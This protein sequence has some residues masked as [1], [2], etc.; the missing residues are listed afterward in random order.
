MRAKFGVKSFSDQR[1]YISNRVLDSFVAAAGEINE[2]MVEWVQ[3]QMLYGYPNPVL[4]TGATFDS[5]EAESATSGSNKVTITVSAGTPYAGYVH[6]GTY[7]MAAR[8]FIRDG[9]EGHITDM[10]LIIGSRLS[11][12]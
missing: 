4:D 5:I 1:E 10:S 7:K 11:E 3:Y 2:N 8:P 9:M 12:L 6:N